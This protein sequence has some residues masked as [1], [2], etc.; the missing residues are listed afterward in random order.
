MRLLTLQTVVVATDLDA[1]SHAAVDSA[2]RLAKA[3][4]ARLHVLHVAPADAGGGNRAVRATEQVSAVLRAQG[5]PAGA[6]EVHV[7]SGAAASTI[8]S[9][10]DRMAAEVVVVGPH[11]T[12]G[13]QRRRLGGTARDLVDGAYAPCLVVPRPLR[14]PLARVLVP[15]DFSDT[16]RGAL[17]AGLSWAS[18]LRAPA[19]PKGSTSLTALH[20]NDADADAA[21]AA[22]QMDQALDVLRDGP[23]GWTGVEIGGR[24]ERGTDAAQVIGKCADDQEVDLLVIGT[25]GLGAGAESRLGSVSAAVAERASLPTLLIPPAVWRVH[26]RRPEPSRTT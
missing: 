20:V 21:A 15:I 8:R 5:V 4:G 13:D 14:L 2:Y 7:I 16:S 1:G 10:A 22:L 19:G 9:F 3:A 26:A 11:R 24:I 18:A 6:A 25:R 17:L 12:S 23:Q